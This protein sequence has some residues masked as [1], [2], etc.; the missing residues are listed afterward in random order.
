MG[1]LLTIIFMAWVIVSLLPS[2]CALNKLLKEVYGILEAFEE[3][4]ENEVEWEISVP[5]LAFQAQGGIF[6]LFAARN[7]VVT[8]NP[9][10]S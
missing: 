10:F 7:N 6:G 2:K 1:F 8:L 9:I 5:T 3:I 4:G